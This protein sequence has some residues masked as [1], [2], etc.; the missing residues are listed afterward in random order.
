M[1][2]NLTRPND[3]IGFTS[4]LRLATRRVRIDGSVV[5]EEEGDEIEDDH[6]DTI[7]GTSLIIALVLCSDNT[8]ENY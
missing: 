4:K 7:D 3:D 6:R 2:L 5:V 1:N 8:G